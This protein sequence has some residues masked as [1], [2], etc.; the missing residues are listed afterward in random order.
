MAVRQGGAGRHGQRPQGFAGSTASSECHWCVSCLCCLIKWADHLSTNS[1]NGT[2]MVDKVE[3]RLGGVERGAS[4]LDTVKKLHDNKIFVPNLLNQLLA[5]EPCR[6]CPPHQ[7]SRP[8][9]ATTRQSWRLRTAI[10]SSQQAP[11]CSTNPLSVPTQCYS[12]DLSE[13]MQKR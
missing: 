11:F 8:R 10:R 6:D 2:R 13:S 3:I 4:L 7:H 1:A 9:S 5:P 12:P